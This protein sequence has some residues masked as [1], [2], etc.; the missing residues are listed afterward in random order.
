MANASAQ[1][2]IASIEISGNS[3]FSQ[4]QLLEK[5]PARIG[6][7]V[8][9]IDQSFPVLTDLY[10]EEGFY[11]FSIDS[12]Q[13]EF[14]EDSSSVR[15]KLFLRENIRTLVSAVSVSGNRAFSSAQLLPLIE[16]SAG[17]PLQSSLLEADIR[18]ILEHY[19]RNGFPFVSVTSDKVRIDE[20]DSSSLSVELE[21]H[22]GG[23]VFV[24]EIKTEGNGT[25]S[26]EVIIR[27]SGIHRGEVFDERKLE[28]FRRRLERM[29]LFSSVGE[30]QLYILSNSLDDSLRGGIRISVKEGNANTFD[31]I[32]GYVPA[33]PPNSDGYF[34]GNVFVAMRNLFGTGR[35]ALVK[36][37]RE[38]ETTQELELQYR[39]PWLFGYPASLGGTFYQRKQDS[40]YVKTRFDVRGDF[41]LSDVLTVGVNILT[42]SVYP[43]SN[44]TQFI[45]FESNTLSFGGEI[46][47][48]TRDYLRNPTDG[49]RYS[50]TVQQG[51]KHITGPQQYLFLAAEKDFTVRKFAMDAEVY[52]SF[53]VR[54]V[55]MLG[56]HGKQVTSTQLEL[57]DLYS[58]GGTTS[59]RGY[60]ES[61]FF[62]SQIAY[63]NTEYRFLTGRASSFFGFIDA[64]Y[65]SRPA[66]PRKGTIRQEKS[67]VGYGLGARIETG[68][69]IM[70]IS[71]ALGEGDSFSN[72]KIH[73]GINNEF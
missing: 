32:I 35:K 6:A 13:K 28:L 11:S 9:A 18:S 37:Q 15:I 44:L 53:I 55:L 60:R 4:R 7:S 19:S 52:F 70:N 59:L 2:T 29:Q 71:Y 38:N 50:T 45:V 66:D 46:L 65:F 23:K 61:Q 25:T 5:I 49:I 68:V 30:P 58:F 41:I 40:S 73:V 54:Q 33:T 42:E 43:A 56:I 69:G 26:T 47:Y 21:I 36:W 12:V 1:P 51:K 22:E 57:S 34:T 16:T 31:G 24:D 27:E 72:G 64:G 17:T 10:H 14:S 3:F 67:L 8:D 20:R 48:D 63:I 39:E 62:A